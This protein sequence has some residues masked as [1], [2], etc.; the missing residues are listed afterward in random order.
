ME[1]VI[2]EWNIRQIEAALETA[3]GRRRLLS[4]LRESPCHV[5]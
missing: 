5:A 1:S 3:S 4:K 2:N